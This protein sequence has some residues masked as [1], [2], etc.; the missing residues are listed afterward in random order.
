MKKKPEEFTPKKDTAD[1]VVQMTI[2]GEEVIG[3]GCFYLRY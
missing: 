1:N 3:Q 2:L